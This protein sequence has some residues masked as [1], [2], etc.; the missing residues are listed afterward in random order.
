MM[1]NAVRDADREQYHQDAD[2]H[3][4]FPNLAQDAFASSVVEGDRRLCILKRAPSLPRLSH[5]R[6]RKYRGDA[7]KKNYRKLTRRQNI[8]NSPYNE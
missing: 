2:P 5:G 1:G 4:P 3:L 8:V 7:T 6:P